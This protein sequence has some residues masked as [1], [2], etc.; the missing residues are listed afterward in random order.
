MFG[1]NTMILEKTKDLGDETRLA[2]HIAIGVAV[3]TIVGVALLAYCQ[4]VHW[5]LFGAVSA[6]IGIGVLAAS[7]LALWKA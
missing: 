3:L 5:R 6:G 7:K 2:R 4:G 1:V